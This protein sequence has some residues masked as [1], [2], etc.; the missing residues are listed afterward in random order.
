VREAGEPHRRRLPARFCASMT[1][2]D[3]LHGVPWWEGFW[4]RHQGSALVA[5]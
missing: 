1:V 3:L 2:S 5:L 4:L